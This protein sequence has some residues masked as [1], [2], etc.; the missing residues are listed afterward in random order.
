LDLITDAAGA[1]KLGE[2]LIDYLVEP[3]LFSDDWIA[4]WF[5]RA[6]LYARLEWAGGV[7]ENADQP[8]PGDFGP[9]AAAQLETVAWRGHRIRVPPLELQL[10]VC[11]QRGLLERVEMIKAL[12]G[13]G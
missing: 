10:Q 13:A 8:Q 11:Q 3:V 5:G 4:D 9:T 7:N 6:F 1:L 12:L 2:L